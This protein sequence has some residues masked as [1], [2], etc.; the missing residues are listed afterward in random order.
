MKIIFIDTETTG[1][2]CQK[3]DIIQIAGL[4]TEDNKILD[5]FNFKCQPINWDTISKQALQINNTTVEDLKSY[6]MPQATFIHFLKVLEKHFSGE[7]FIIAGQNVKSFDWRFVVTFWENHKRYADPEFEFYF[8]DKVSLDLLD[9]SRP[10]K[11]HGFLD[12]P[13]VKLGTIVEALNITVDGELHDALA[14]IKAT[15]QGFY[16]LVNKVNEIRRTKPN[17]PIF[18]NEKLN[19]TMELFWDTTPDKKI[20]LL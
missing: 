9:L 18:E 10:L 3:H 8:D 16:G 20:S 15:Q 19:N 13:N 2:S 12:V 6:E 14:D 17:H 11:N 4:V 1:L 5:E 7:K